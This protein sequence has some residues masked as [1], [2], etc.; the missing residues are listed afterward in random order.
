MTT[1]E[2]MH[3]S[4]VFSGADIWRKCRFP[5]GTVSFMLAGQWAARS[6]AAPALVGFYLSSELVVALNSGP[7]LLF[8]L[9]L[10]A[11]ESLQQE[12]E[13]MCFRLRRGFV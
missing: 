2:L 7:S 3:S 4:V 10:Y 13:V 11:L 5:N 8:S 1:Y 9:C 6:P 12:F